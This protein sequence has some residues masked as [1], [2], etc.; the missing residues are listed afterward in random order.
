MIFAQLLIL[1]IPFP[2]LPTFVIEMQPSR[3]RT[4]GDVLLKSKKKPEKPKK[5]L[6]VSG[7]EVTIQRRD[8]AYE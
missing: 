1:A 7:T 5:T 4:N 6:S 2:Y 8:E 3:T